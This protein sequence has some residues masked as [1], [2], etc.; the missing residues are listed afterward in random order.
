MIT[1]SGDATD[2][3]DGTLPASAYTWNIDFLHDNHVHPGTA[4]TGVKSGSF[5]IPSTGHDFEGN[6]R[7]RIQLTVTDSDGLQS[8][9]VVTIW[10]DKV[11]LPFDTSPSG[12]TLYIDGVARTTPFVLDTIVG[13]N[14]TIEARDQTSG[15]SSYSFGSWSD[16]GAQ[17]H[18]ITVPATSRSFTA[19]YVQST[20]ACRA[21]GASTRAAARPRRTRP[22][23]ATPRPLTNGPSR[24]AGKHGNAVS[25]DG[26]NDYLQVPNSASLDVAGTAL[27]MSAL[28]QPARD[29]RR[30]GAPRQ[31]L[32]LDDDLTLLPVRN[33]VRRRHGA[34]LLCRD[35]GRDSQARAWEARCPWASGAMWP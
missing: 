7:Y 20:A 22:A 1:Y 8:T 35:C 33:R 34:S 30:L 24:V 25:L 21:P 4:V 2:P 12:L 27:T 3:E 19:T 14:H 17:T 15:S 13:F 29:F 6:T 32:E 16:G 31:V 26:V 28:G 11:N 23:T 18:T 5:T 9:K 10:P